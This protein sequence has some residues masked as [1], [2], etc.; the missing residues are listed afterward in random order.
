MSDVDPGEQPEIST[1]FDASALPDPPSL[2]DELAAAEAAADA[3]DPAA[4]PAPPSADSAAGVEGG[5]VGVLAAVTA[6]RDGYLDALQR[7]KAEFAN[8]RRRTGE[9]AI[10]QR[11]QAAAG[12]VTKLLPVLDSCDA[13]MQHGAEA[14]TPIASSLRDVLAGAGLTAIDALNQP[15]DPEVHEAVLHEEAEAGETG[16]PIVSEVLRTGYMLNGVV[17]RASMVKVRG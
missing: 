15:F 14:V 13:A 10:A 4:P 17:V 7:L 12:L 8:H 2:E 5:A 11:E 1:D 16:G 9:Q 3:A 6:E